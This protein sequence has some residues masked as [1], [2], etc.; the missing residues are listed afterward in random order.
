MHPTSLRVG[1]INPMQTDFNCSALSADVS[2]IATTCNVFLDIVLVFCVNER[3]VEL[4]GTSA[5][6][7]AVPDDTLRKL[8]L[9]VAII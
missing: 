4:A 7:K 2:A 6:S 9:F 3:R 5:A 1:S 8:R